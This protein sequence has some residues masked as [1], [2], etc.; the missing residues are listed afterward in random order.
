[1]LAQ[2]TVSVYLR[3]T[4]SASKNALP[5][6]PRSSK[7]KGSSRFWLSSCIWVF[8]VKMSEPVASNKQK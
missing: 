4:G 7:R 1:M 5:S 2:L 8:T 3:R 6:L